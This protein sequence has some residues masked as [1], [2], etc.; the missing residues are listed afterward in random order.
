MY[1]ASNECSLHASC[2][3]AM[4]TRPAG[5][6]LHLVRVGPTL[7]QSID[8]TERQRAPTAQGTSCCASHYSAA[9]GHDVTRAVI[10]CAGSF[11][12][13]RFIPYGALFGAPLE[14]D[15]IVVGRKDFSYTEP[16]TGTPPP[17]P[18]LLHIHLQCPLLPAHTFSVSSS[19][20]RGMLCSQF[21]VRSNSP[22]ARRIFSRS[23][24]LPRFA[25]MDHTLRHQLLINRARRTPMICSSRSFSNQAPRALFQS[26]WLEVRN[27]PPSAHCVVASET[28]HRTTE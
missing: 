15:S 9:G 10:P 5:S 4:Q 27:A 19:N 23:G 22:P 20:C 16:T 11:K 1:A 8:L 28:P 24:W 26:F 7:N 12:P 21:L 17:P 13:Q 25:V 6:V 2:L 3:Q 14:D 18:S